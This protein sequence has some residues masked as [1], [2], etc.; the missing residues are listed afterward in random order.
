M[1][2]NFQKLYGSQAQIVSAL[3]I[4]FDRLSVALLLVQPQVRT[5]IDASAGAVVTNLPNGVDARGDYYYIKLDNSVNIVTI[6]PFG[7]QLIE[8]AGSYTLSS[9]F[10]RVV[11]TFHRETQQWLRI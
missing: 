9:Q 1:N 7:S 4:N 5:F 3:E 2:V 11:L 10:D 8:G 6:T